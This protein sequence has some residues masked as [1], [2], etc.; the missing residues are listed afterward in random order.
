MLFAHVPLPRSEL[1]FQITA[2]AG[3]LP[4]RGNAQHALVTVQLGLVP[5]PGASWQEMTPGKRPVAAGQWSKHGA[6]SRAEAA[7]GSC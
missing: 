5:L 3:R 7:A 6:H 1:G 4:R 2:L